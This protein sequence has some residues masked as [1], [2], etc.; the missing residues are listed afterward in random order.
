M[1]SARGGEGSKG[2]GSVPP[3]EGGVFLD[4]DYINLSVGGAGERGTLLL[5]VTDRTI[6]VLRHHLKGLYQLTDKELA[7]WNRLRL[8]DKQANLQHHFCATP[9]QIETMKKKLFVKLKAGKVNTVCFLA[10]VHRV[11]LL[12]EWAAHYFDASHE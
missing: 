7:L 6:E 9:K 12:D 11:D 1:L 4:G 2:G 3:A 8:D 10:G 5:R